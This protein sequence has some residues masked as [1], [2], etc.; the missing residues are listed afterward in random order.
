MSQSTARR[1]RDQI[2]LL[3]DQPQLPFS[4]LLD[5]EMV[6]EVLQEQGVRYRDR[7]Y[8]PLVTLWT[9]L[10]QVLSVDHCCRKA[11]AGLIAYRTARGQEPCSAET[12]SYCKAR[13]R[14]LVGVIISLVR[15]IALAIDERAPEGWLWKRREVVLV[16][17]STF[18]MPDTPKNQEAFPQAKTQAR[19]LGFPIARMVA[20][21]SLATGVLRDLAIGPYKGKET[22]ETALLRQL[23]DRLK[24]GE[25][26]LGDRYFASY[27]GIASLLERGVDGLFRMHQLRKYDF[28][29][30]KR[31]GISDHVVSWT[32][33]A[34]PSWMSP[35]DYD[36]VP[37]TLRIRELRILVEQ[38]GFR[39]DELILVTTM[40]DPLGYT[41]DELAALYFERWNIELDLRSI[42]CVMQMDVLRCETPEMVIKEAWM[43]ALAYNLIRGLMAAAAEAHG[44]V[45]RQISFAGTLQ[46][47]AAFREILD[48]VPPE[49][50]QLLVDVMLRAIATHEV[51][52]RPGRVEPRAI[53]RRPKPH[54]LLTEPRDQARKRLRNAA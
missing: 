33:P 46:T 26:L 2:N 45:P 48:L 12:G 23:L 9:F 43:H 36:R 25:V 44:K 42:K 35:E 34:R 10:S 8:S 17:G 14:L 18:S 32:K 54:D 31:L 37:E 40:L 21:I 24:G 52:D 53:K 19:G 51:G 30:G 1:I 49:T 50:R 3:R 29:R 22:G 38:P 13:R 16:D 27:F 41:K 6:E 20:I 4:D 47:M 5:A 11:V 7:I 28:R 15:R 39:V